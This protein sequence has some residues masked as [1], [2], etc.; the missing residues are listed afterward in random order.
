MTEK[1]HI[2]PVYLHI[3][4]NNLVLVSLFV[5]SSVYNKPDFLNIVC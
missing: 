5:Y 3:V 1:Q 4:V 2:R